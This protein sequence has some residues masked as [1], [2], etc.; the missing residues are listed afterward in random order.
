MLVYHE[1][2]N[3]FEELKNDL[4]AVDHYCVFLYSEG[5]DLNEFLN[6]DEQFCTT[7][8]KEFE[9]YLRSNEFK[10]V[11]E[12]YIPVIRTISAVHID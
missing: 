11:R 2:S 3:Q 8:Q 6:R 7:S 4:N 1:G 10:I 12:G 9:K 5:E